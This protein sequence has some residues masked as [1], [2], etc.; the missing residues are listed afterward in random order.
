MHRELLGVCCTGQD[1]LQQN[2]SHT[3]DFGRDA[4]CP[5]G[6]IG[7]L[8]PP[9]RLGPRGAA[10]QK[11]LV[12][13]TWGVALRGDKCALKL[14]QLGGELGTGCAQPPGWGQGQRC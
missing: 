7:T 1:H 2:R 11:A 12:P 4:A 13:V 14:S 3:G 10:S 8:L 6:W 5:T 9:A